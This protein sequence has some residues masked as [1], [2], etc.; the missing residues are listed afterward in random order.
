LEITGNSEKLNAVL[1]LLKVVGIQEVV[2][3]GSLAIQRM[4]KE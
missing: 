1:G 2:R 4:K 3:T